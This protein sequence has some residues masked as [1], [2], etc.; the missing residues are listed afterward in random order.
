MYKNAHLQNITPGPKVG[1]EVRED[2]ISQSWHWEKK[3]R[4]AIIWV[5]SP[6]QGHN[7]NCIRPKQTLPQIKAFFSGVTSFDAHTKLICQQQNQTSEYQTL[8][9]DT[10]TCEVAR[11]NIKIRYALDYFGANTKLQQPTSNKKIKNFY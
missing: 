1:M 11:K 8:L 2:L 4:R 10:L 6:S 9:G 7:L 5:F 3:Q